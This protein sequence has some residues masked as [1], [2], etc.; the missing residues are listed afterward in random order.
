ME[1]IIRFVTLAQTDRFTIAD[2]CEQFFSSQL[3][4]WST[5]LASKHAL[6]G[7]AGRARPVLASCSAFYPV[8]SG[9]LGSR[10]PPLASNPTE[11]VA[12]EVLKLPAGCVGVTIS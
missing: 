7:W 1:E 2:R 5:P 10:S 9:A 11:I 6:A 8:R 4:R 12:S 3:F